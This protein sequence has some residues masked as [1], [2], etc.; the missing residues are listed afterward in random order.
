MQTKKSK[1]G[2]A[3]ENNEVVDELNEFVDELE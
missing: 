3:V 2:K 1:N